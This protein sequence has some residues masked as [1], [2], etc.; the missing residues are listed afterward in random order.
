MKI[1]HFA[2]A[3]IDISQSGKVDPITG[4]PLRVQ[5]FL[6]SLDVIVDTAITEKADLVLFAGDAYRDR[7][8]LPTY[9]REWEKRVLR[10]SQAKIPTILL[11]GNHDMPKSS[12]K[13]HA[14]EEFETLQ[15]P[16]IH[17][18]SKVKMLTPHELG[19]PIQVI[20]LPWLY[21]SRTDMYRQTTP[22]ALNDLDAQMEDAVSE[23]LNSFLTRRDEALPTILLAH[24]AITGASIGDERELMLGGDFQLPPGLVKDP[25]LDYVALGHIHK[26]QNLN[27]PG[28]DQDNKANNHPPV[29][30]PGSIERVNFGE[31][32][33]AK[34]FVIAD[35]G[36]GVTNIEWRKLV[37]VRPFIKCVIKIDPATHPTDQIL[38]NLPPR[39]EINGAVVHIHVDFPPGTQGGIDEAPVIDHCS[40]AFELRF[41]TRMQREVRSRL[42]QDE[43]TTAMSDLD[44][45]GRYLDEHKNTAYDRE[46]LTNLAMTILEGDAGGDAE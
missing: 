5:D 26:A 42:A 18:A 38:A 39:E 32:S 13:A 12:T 44:L 9:Q 41:T 37:N 33:D 4:I 21:R 23:V 11:T 40:N 46:K 45:F 14:L 29:I 19:L 16:Y 31:R 24:A 35:V 22:N 15:I 30:Y 25:R 36:V 34:Y 8:P 28:P 27:G 17:I 7:T 43:N 6:R 3:H 1:V 2:D 20:T 10:L